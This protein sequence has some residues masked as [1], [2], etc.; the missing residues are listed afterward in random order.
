MKK[1]LF[2]MVLGCLLDSAIYGVLFITGT[3]LLLGETKY[4]WVGYIL[5][6]LAFVLLAT[7]SF[8]MR[9][10]NLRMDVLVQHLVHKLQHATMG[11]LF[12]SAMSD[13]EELEGLEENEG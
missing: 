11:M 10:V 9:L 3:G 2:K 6:G 7:S 12:K 8:V 4:A 13:K 5:L 1:V